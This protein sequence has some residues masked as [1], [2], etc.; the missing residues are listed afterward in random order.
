MGI[1]SGLVSLKSTYLDNESVTMKEQLGYAGGIFGNAMGQDSVGTFAGNF[2]RDYMGLTNAMSAVKDNVSTIL[3][4]IVPPIAGALYDRPLKKG[5][6]SPLRTALFVAPIPF[7]V[8]SMLLFVVPANN[9]MYNFIWTLFFS[10]LFSVADTFYDI[11]LSS[12]ALKM[13]SDPADRKKFYTFESIASTLGSLLP[14]GVIPIV[15]GMT[16]DPLKQ[17]WRYFF[18][19]LGF[20]IIGVAAMYTPYMTIEERASFY[21]PSENSKEEKINW[22][23]DTVSALLHNKPFMILQ[24]ANIFETIRKVTYDTLI[25]LYKNTFDDL[26]MKTIIET[27]SGALSY[28]GLLSV[29]FVGKKL[30]AKAML[31]GGFFYTGFFYAIIS[32]FNINFNLEKVRKLRYIPGMCI[33]FAGMPNA[34]QGAARKIITGDST[35]FMEWY[36][37]KKYGVPVRSDG[38]LSAAQNIVS[39][40][41]S[42][43]KVNLTNG[44][45]ALI[46]YQS[47]DMTTGKQAVQTPETLRGIYRVV[48]LCGLIGNFLPAIILL[49]DDY[50]GAKKEKIYAEL[51][52]MREKRNKLEAELN[53]Q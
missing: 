39:K 43:I 40:I 48:S 37:E 47:K 14:G 26:K 8:T 11:A 18:I 15:V 13:V 10:I 38:L 30:S 21:T 42:L 1:K 2:G 16:D 49:F 46:K 5:K 23:K 35:D 51:C 3:S 29:P 20:C 17:Q 9:A 31:S 33:A 22:D 27:I 50:S 52:E 53:E 25:Y 44:L 7:A 36:S 4:F 41:T 24:I 12:L 6:R 32:S 45:L 19:A 28:V 34:A